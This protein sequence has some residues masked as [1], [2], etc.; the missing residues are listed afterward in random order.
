VLDQVEEG[1]LRPLQIVEDDDERPLA[2][3]CSSNCR[4]LTCVSSGD[5]PTTSPGLAPSWNTISTSGQ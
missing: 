1:R 2:A 3:C 4:N 5:V